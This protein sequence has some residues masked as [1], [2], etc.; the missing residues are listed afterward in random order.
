MFLIRSRAGSHAAGTRGKVPETLTGTCGPMRMLALCVF[1]CING[2]ALAVEEGSLE[3]CLAI[4]TKMN[5]YSDKRR[6]GGLETQMRSWKHARRK[7]QR[8]FRQHRCY[9]FGGQLK[10]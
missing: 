3:H 4:Q 8:E 9:R 10:G 7:A 6:D 1:L 2:V 5:H